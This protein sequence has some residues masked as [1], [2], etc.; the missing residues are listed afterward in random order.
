[1]IHFLL[2]VII[3]VKYDV[4]EVLWVLEL[5]VDSWANALDS[6]ALKLLDVMSELVSTDPDFAQISLLFQNPLAWRIELAKHK[7]FFV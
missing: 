2:V 7:H 4:V 1:M 5:K 6:L 3:Q